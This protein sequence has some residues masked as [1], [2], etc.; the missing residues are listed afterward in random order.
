MKLI[1]LTFFLTISYS[2]K[3]LIPMDEY[4][5]NHLKAYGVAYWVLNKNNNLDWLLNYRGGSFLIDY[6]KE[7]ENE[8]IL[9][10]VTYNIINLN[11]LNEIYSVIEE[12]NMEI[13]I[14]EKS[15]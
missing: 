10:G 8:C 2:Q 3:L 9:R 11:N 15:P 7:I 13:V 4:Q 1:L 14:L 12:N 6:N 5:N